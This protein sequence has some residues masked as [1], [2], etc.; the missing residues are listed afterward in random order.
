MITSFWVK[1]LKYW[2][3]RQGFFFSLDCFSIV[4][5]F[6]EFLK[7]Y[8]RA[9][10]SPKIFW[11]FMILGKKFPKVLYVYMLDIKILWF[12]NNV[13]N[14]NIVW[15]YL[16]KL[17]F[18]SIIFLFCKRNR[19]IYFGVKNDVTIKIF[20]IWIFCFFNLLVEFGK[21]ILQQQRIRVI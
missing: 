19:I 2:F 5:S 9:I 4:F 8:C 15:A 18:K 21:T 20:L 7:Y 10:F 17:P 14:C 12:H 11:Y 6:N 1:I 13:Q 3:A 16:V